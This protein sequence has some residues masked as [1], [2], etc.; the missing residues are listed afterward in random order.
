M[1]KPL[2]EP[3]Q[4]PAL[5]SRPLAPQVFPTEYRANMHLKFF[6][7]L[8]DNAYA[9][10][11]KC[12]LQFTNF[13]ALMQANVALT[14]V[15]RQAH[16][17]LQYIVARSWWTKNA[18]SLIKNM[19]NSFKNMPNKPKQ[20][21][22]Y[23]FWTIQ[24]S[25]DKMRCYFRTKPGS[26]AYKYCFNLQQCHL[27]YRKFVIRNSYRYMKQYRLWIKPTNMHHATVLITFNL[28]HNQLICYICHMSKYL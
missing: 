15:R 23:R 17:G 7:Q 8:P 27:S 16:V 2:T 21:G 3:S 22:S 25:K 28:V 5:N 10:H 13:T 12:P 18:K 20:A 24:M 1:W 14:K 9:C 26:I 11:S 6:L 4:T 19:P